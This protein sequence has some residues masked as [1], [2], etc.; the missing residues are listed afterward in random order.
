[1]ENGNFP[2]YF[3]QNDYIGKIKTWGKPEILVDK[4]HNMYLQIAVNDGVIALICFIIFIFNYLKSSVVRLINLKDRPT[5]CYD[6][7]IL[8][9]VI[10]YLISGIFNDSFIGVTPIFCILLGIGIRF[11]LVSN[12]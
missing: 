2:M 5:Y 11:N 10:S 12:I 1:M 9:G 3:P 7:S 4:C 6:L 8:C